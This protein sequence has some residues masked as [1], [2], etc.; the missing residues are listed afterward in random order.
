MCTVL[1]PVGDNS[2][3]FNKDIHININISGLTYETSP[4]C[5]LTVSVVT[6]HK[7]WR[8]YASSVE[9]TL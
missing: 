8:S 1:Q 6:G 3:A 5:T 2:F 9:N 4:I 7:P